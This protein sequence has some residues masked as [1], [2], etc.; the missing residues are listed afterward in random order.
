M[1]FACSNKLYLSRSKQSENHCRSQF[2][3]V[4]YF[5]DRNG[6]VANEDY[7][8]YIISSSRS[9]SC[10]IYIYIQFECVC[11]HFGGLNGDRVLHVVDMH[12]HT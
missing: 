8:D 1:K 6:N 9:C 11:S 12:T 5:V 4:S 3:N 2:T 7:Y 10:G